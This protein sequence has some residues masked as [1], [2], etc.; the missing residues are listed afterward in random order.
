MDDILPEN[1]LAASANIEH[2]VSENAE[3][4]RMPGVLATINA[5][6]S[7][8]ERKK[9]KLDKMKQKEVEKKKILQGL[10]ADSLDDQRKRT[11]LND[12]KKEL[13]KKEEDLMKR[14]KEL[15]RQKE[16]LAIHSRAVDEETTNIVKRQEERVAKISKIKAELENRR[17]FRLQEESELEK[18]PGLL[19]ALMK[20]WS[21]ARGG[22]GWSWTSRC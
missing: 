3:E 14:D 18:G 15:K 7:M 17:A 5:L 9:S 2:K 22:G 8:V 13:M 6:S 20:T 1:S 12:A 4:D 11:Y 21:W 19:Q 16:D 10:E